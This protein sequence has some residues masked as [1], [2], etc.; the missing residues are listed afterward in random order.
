MTVEVRGAP[1]FY[2]RTAEAP[3]SHACPILGSRQALSVHGGTAK[4]ENDALISDLYAPQ[5]PSSMVDV[6]VHKQSLHHTVFF[7]E[8]SASIFLAAISLWA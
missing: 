5:P 1:Y 3:E 7:S 4:L 2:G 6:S 8:N